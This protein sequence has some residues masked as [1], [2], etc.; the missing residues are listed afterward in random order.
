MFSSSLCFQSTFVTGNWIK[1]RMCQTR[2][3]SFWNQISPMPGL[4]F[5]SSPRYAYQAPTEPTESVSKH[6]SSLGFDFACAPFAGLQRL[7]RWQPS[8]G[9]FDREGRRMGTELVSQTPIV[10]KF[11]P[12]RSAPPDLSRQLRIFYFVRMWEHLRFFHF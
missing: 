10:P 6:S 1:K 7:V 9:E 4:S 8:D 5:V 12:T 2:G 3:A 11:V